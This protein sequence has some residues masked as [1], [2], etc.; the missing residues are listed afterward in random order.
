MTW[1]SKCHIYVVPLQL[2]YQTIMAE[3]YQGLI[4]TQPLPTVHVA[5]NTLAVV[6][7]WMPDPFR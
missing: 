3:R 1:V 7:V 6:A 5:R 4:E 2:Y